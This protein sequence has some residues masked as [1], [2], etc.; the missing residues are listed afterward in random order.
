MGL[1][2][3]VQH[4]ASIADG[5]LVESQ[6]IHDSNSELYEAGIDLPIDRKFSLPEVNVEP[7]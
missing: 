4:Q 2:C 3:V 1:Q 6:V 7:E 5:W